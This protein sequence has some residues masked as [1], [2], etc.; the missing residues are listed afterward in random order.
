MKKAINIVT[1]VAASLT[2]AA[3]AVTLAAGVLEVIQGAKK[4]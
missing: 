1:L 2:A 4:K 3:A